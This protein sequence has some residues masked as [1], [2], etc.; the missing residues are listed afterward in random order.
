MK[1]TV[2]LFSVFILIGFFAF[3][4][5]SLIQEKGKSPSKKELSSFQ[6]LSYFKN[7]R[8]QSPKPM[9]LPVKK[10]YSDKVSLLK[11]LLSD[12]HG[13][14]KPIKMQK[15]DFSQQPENNTVYWLGHSSAILELSGL[16]IG[17]D[18]VFDN[19]SP[20]PRTVKRYQEAPIKRQNLPEFDYI[21]ITHNH[22]DHLERKTVQSIKKGHFIVPYGMKTTLIHWGISPD[23]ITETGW[24]ETLEENGIK[25]TATEGVHYSSRGL[26]DRNK[27]L[28]NSY[29]IETP[30]QKIFWGG[31]SGY[32]RHFSEIGEKFGPFDW[33]AL[34]IDAWNKD[35]STIHL[36]P[37]QAVRA[38]RDLKA[39]RLLPIHWGAY[40]LAWHQWDV[41]IRKVVEEIKN[42]AI[43]LMTP[44]MGQKLIPGV[45]K[46]SH[47]WKESPETGTNTP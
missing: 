2:L 26:F 28:W 11:L 17:I 6:K 44:E 39:K 23:R 38:A 41:S 34:E 24:R 18:L 33:V 14:K 15:P 3:L 12:S 9:P 47:W 31:D 35:W 16:R 8:F 29:I 4:F 27:S 19:A 25:I 10:E 36:F 32:G 7:G 30:H 21:L 1:K 22:Y 42:S 43:E 20:V 40:D 37:D 45:T 5:F 46:T 13:P